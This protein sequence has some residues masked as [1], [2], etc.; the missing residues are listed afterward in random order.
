[1]SSKK[2]RDGSVPRK[3]AVPGLDKRQARRLASTPRTMG[4]E[5][6]A[7]AERLQ[8]WMDEDIDVAGDYSPEPAV[9]QA[10]LDEL[11]ANTMALGSLEAEIEQAAVRVGVDLVGDD[12]ERKG[13]LQLLGE[14]TVLAGVGRILEQPVRFWKC[15]IAEHDRKDAVTVDWRDG[16]AYCTAPG[17]RQNSVRSVRASARAWRRASQEGSL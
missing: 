12:S 16:I 11:T 6:S 8:A 14:I 1:M 9:V 2:P 5:M 4:V 15:P 10:V 13:A 3:G 17:C 7:A